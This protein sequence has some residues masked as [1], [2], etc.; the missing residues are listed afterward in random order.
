[1]ISHRAGHDSLQK[2]KAKLEDKDQNDP[3]TF[4]S[5]PHASIVLFGKHKPP[6]T[7]GMLCLAALVVLATSPLVTSDGS[8][9]LRLHA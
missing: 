2:T 3:H 1:M 7:R 4:N 9:E 6:N 8:D 5:A